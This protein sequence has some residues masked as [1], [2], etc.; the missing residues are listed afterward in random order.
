MDRKPWPQSCQYLTQELPRESWTT[1]PHYTGLIRFWLSRHNGFRKKMLR[2]QSET[3]AILD[4]MDDPAG[5]A[6]SMHQEAGFLINGLKG[7]HQIEDQHFF[8]VLRNLD[9]RARKGFEI[10]ESDHLMVD[11]LLGRFSRDT[12][13][14]LYESAQKEEFERHAACVLASLENLQAYLNRHLEDEEDIVV[15]VL[16][17]YAPDDIR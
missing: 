16:L 11:H 15:P 8:P 3:K 13:S 9:D 17:K 5:F 12:H 10:L 1:H 7:H 6:H 2:L 14:L 4:T